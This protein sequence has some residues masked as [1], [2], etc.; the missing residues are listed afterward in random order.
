M[1]EPELA[2]PNMGLPVSE[3]GPADERFSCA[4]SCPKTTSNNCLARINAGIIAAYLI[5]RTFD[6]AYN[7]L[8]NLPYVLSQRADSRG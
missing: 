1:N 2:V 5:C 4:A 3:L 7:D 6:Y 8:S